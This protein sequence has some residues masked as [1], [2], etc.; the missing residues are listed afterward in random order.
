MQMQKKKKFD[1]ICEAP[2]PGFGITEEE[3]CL[4]L[5]LPF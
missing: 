5:L 3:C 2:I 1:K 4:F